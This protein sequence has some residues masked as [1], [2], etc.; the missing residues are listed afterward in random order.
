MSSKKARAFARVFC[1]IS[2]NV[3]FGFIRDFIKRDVTPGKLPAIDGF[4]AC[5]SVEV[6]RKI[7][8]C[9]S[10]KY[11]GYDAGRPMLQLRTLAPYG[12]TTSSI[13]A[14]RCCGYSREDGA[15]G[16]DFDGCAK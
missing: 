4:R 10:P 9:G 12:I 13:K 5:G 1:Q 15:N 8:L 2:R 3:Y 11:R 7:C 14:L 16:S 6:F